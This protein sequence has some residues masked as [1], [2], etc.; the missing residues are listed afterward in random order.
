MNIAKQVQML[1]KL[2]A[3]QSFAIIMTGESNFIIELV[4]WHNRECF[5]SYVCHGNVIWAYMLSSC[6]LW[7]DC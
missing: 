5:E 1:Q 3:K 6:S 2:D 7:V 4:Q